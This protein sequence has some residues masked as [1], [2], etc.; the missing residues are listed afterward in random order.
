MAEECDEKNDWNRY[1]EQ[2]KQ[3]GTQVRF[4]LT[5]E[6][7]KHAQGYGLGC[8]KSSILASPA[9]LEALEVRNK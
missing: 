4:D 2:Q 9:D 7:E 3:N 8:A 6:K 5:A 1:A